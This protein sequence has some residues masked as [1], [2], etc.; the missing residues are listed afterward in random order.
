[1]PVAPASRYLKQHIGSVTTWTG[2]G[3]PPI[4]FELYGQTPTL[5]GFA[6]SLK[7]SLYVALGNLMMS[8]LSFPAVVSISSWTIYRRIWKSGLRYRSIR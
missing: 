8:A 7:A 6:Q 1:M 3:C 2:S 4:T 5:K